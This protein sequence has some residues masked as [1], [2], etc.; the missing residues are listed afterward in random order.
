MLASR[1][2]GLVCQMSKTAF[3]ITAAGMS[4]RFSREL[5]RDALKCIYT[6]GGP[7]DAILHRLVTQGLNLKLGP[8][9]VVGGYKMNE[10]VEFFTAHLNHPSVCL[11]ENPLYRRGSLYS[12]Y[13]GLV[14]AL[15]DPSVTEIVFA[16][17]DLL[18][19][20]PSLERVIRSRLDVATSCPEPITALRS[21][22]L[23]VSDTDRVRYVY[24]TQHETLRIPEPFRAIYNSGQ[25]WKFKNIGLLRSICDRVTPGRYDD[26][27][28]G[29]IQE[30][31]DSIPASQTELIPF[32]IWHN[33]NTPNDYRRAVAQLRAAEQGALQ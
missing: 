27:N 24:D 31:F 4:T 6:D 33:C 22:A 18:V 2:E 17:G 30:Y 7:E 15:Q 26:T 32:S 16:E 23:Y 1:N 13:L 11:I 3:V 29:V 5:G 9:I 25:V 28:L 21:V 19:D 8:I 12:L 14:E 10:V 20:A